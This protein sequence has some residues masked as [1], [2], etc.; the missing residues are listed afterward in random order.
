MPLATPSCVGTRKSVPATA[1]LNAEA[2]LPF[3]NPEIEDTPVP[4]LVTGRIPVTPLVSG[5]P[6]AFVKTTADGVPRLGVVSVGDVERTIAPVP[7][8]DVVLTPLTDK[9]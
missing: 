9:D 4:P 8:T 6:V 3:T 1:A 7:V 5:N 2:P